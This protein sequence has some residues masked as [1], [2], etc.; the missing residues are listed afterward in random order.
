[1]ALQENLTVFDAE[2]TAENLLLHFRQILLA[3]L[4][5][6]IGLHAVKLYETKS[7]YAEWVAGN[8]PE[9]RENITTSKKISSFN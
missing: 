3:A 7:S 8:Y 9:Y 1:M 6:G 2:P 5:D 4:P